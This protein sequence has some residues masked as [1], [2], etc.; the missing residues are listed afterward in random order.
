MEAMNQGSF[1]THIDTDH[2][3][4]QQRKDRSTPRTSPR[5]TLLLGK[6]SSLVR[7]RLQV[8]DLARHGVDVEDVEQD[9]RIRLWLALKNDST[10]SVPASY[11]QK[12]VLSSIVDSLRRARTKGR[13]K[14]SE[15]D[16]S[17]LE[18]PDHSAQP[19]IAA[20]Q[21]QLAE[22]IQRCLAQLSVRRRQSVRL[23]MYGYSVQE[24]CKVSGISVNAGSKLL[25][26]GL[27]EL[28]T[29]LSKS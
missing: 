14:Y 5:L 21:A 11:V 10:M 23:F 20:A 18:L 1:D 8:H 28:R 19:D 25:R 26:R 3:V 7:S 24:L 6:F 15:L 4:T 12:V 16:V 13:E 22:H 2:V 17:L 9:V 27:G 29:M